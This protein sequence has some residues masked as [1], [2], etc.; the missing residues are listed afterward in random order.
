MYSNI[1][2]GA[3]KESE[4]S[5]VSTVLLVPI[6]WQTIFLTKDLYMSLNQKDLIDLTYNL[7]VR[8]YDANW[9][10]ANNLF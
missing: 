8:T 1:I 6:E 10:V 7:D 9:H 5:L 3:P 2:A 4:S